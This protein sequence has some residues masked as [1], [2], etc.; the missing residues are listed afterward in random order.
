M[1]FSWT[2]E[3][4]GK[5]KCETWIML[6]WTFE[7]CGSREYVMLWIAL[8]WP[9]R[10]RSVGAILDIFVCKLIWVI[11]IDNTIEIIIIFKFMKYGL[12]VWWIMF[13][14]CVILCVK[15]D[16]LLTAVFCLANWAWRLTFWLTESNILMGYLWPGG[17]EV[18]NNFS[19][20]WMR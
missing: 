7:L 6:Q 2:F 11:K 13:Y 4:C 5:R 10:G 3:T 1:D 9:I 19:T 8:L 20:V 18:A 17:V 16:W 12:I 14:N 15:T